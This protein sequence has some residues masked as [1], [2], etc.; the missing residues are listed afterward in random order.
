MPDPTRKHEVSSEIPSEGTDENVATRSSPTRRNPDPKVDPQRE[1]AAGVNQ[2]KVD[3]D[4]T[5]R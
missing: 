4:K 1:S 2:G 5:S 3:P